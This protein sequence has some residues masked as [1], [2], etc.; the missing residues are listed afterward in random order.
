MS[1]TTSGKNGSA[2]PLCLDV[3]ADAPDLAELAGQSHFLSP[4]PLNLAI[5]GCGYWGPKLLR[6]FHSLAHCRVRTICDP[7]DC[8]L[9]ALRSV[10][11]GLK[12]STDYQEVVASNEI[13]AVIVAT[14]LRFHF[15]IAKAALDAGKHTFVE[16]PITAASREAEELNRLASRQRLTLMVGHTFLYTAEVRKLRELISAGA[17]GRLLYITG[18]RMH[19][20]LVRRDCNVLW[21]L[22][23]HDLSILEYILRKSPAR[24]LC[25]GHAYLRPS[26]E[27]VVSLE[28]TYDDGVFVTL[29][30]S[31]LS[32]RKVR[33]MTFVGTKGMIVYDD[34]EPAE[35]LRIYTR[36]P[37]SCSSAHIPLQPVSIEVRDKAEP[38]QVE[39]QHFVDCV[40]NESTPLSDGSSGSALVRI[41]EAA[42]ESLAFKR[43]VELQAC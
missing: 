6:N 33:E 40:R 25:S 26:A 4:A 14:P 11:P 20:G 30:C 43:A 17:I 22:A 41:L 3:A 35:K 37:K 8:R 5:V 27:D 39:C 29:L 12:A 21:D 1:G 31:W 16:K 38:L 24:V 9:S 15:P 42:D 18:R 7:D 34:L 23:P 32:P 19:E 2:R 36:P 28:L 10:Y 13:D